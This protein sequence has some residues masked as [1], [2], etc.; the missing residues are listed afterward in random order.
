MNAQIVFPLL[1][2][3][4]KEAFK[5]TVLKQSC[6]M[7]R[8]TGPMVIR[9]GSIKTGRMIL[10]RE[11]LKNGIIPFVICDENK[12]HYTHLLN[13]AQKTGSFAA[14]AGYFEE[15]TCK[16]YEIL[17]EFLKVYER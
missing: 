7:E 4:E 14:L 10:F 8:F 15:E 11:C 13:A 12:D 6:P 17:Q 16:Y 2:K 9:L 3:E 5:Q 1:V